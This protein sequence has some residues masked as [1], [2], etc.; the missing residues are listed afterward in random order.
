FFNSYRAF[1]EEELA[2]LAVISRAGAARPSKQAGEKG[3]ASRRPESAQSARP[4]AQPAADT[5]PAAP[6]PRHTAEAPATREEIAA[7]ALEAQSVDE[8]AA[9]VSGASPAE[10]A[11]IVELEA[12]PLE[13]EAFLDDESSAVAEAYLTEQG[14]A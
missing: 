4:R 7:D 6:S 9:C 3:A 11:A 12:E 1:L 2:E 14:A 8:E 5:P 10:V 13:P